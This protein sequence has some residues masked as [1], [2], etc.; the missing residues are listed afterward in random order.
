MV[1]DGPARGNHF[2]FND[3]CRPEERERQLAGSFRSGV[4]RSIDGGAT[5]RAAD[6][7]TVPVWV[8]SLVIDPHDSNIVYAADY[9]G[10]FK[11]LDGGLTWSGLET[12]RMNGCWSVTINPRNP[13]IIY[14][15]TGNGDG[16]VL[17]AGVYK[18]MDAGKSWRK[19][20]G[21]PEPQL[22]DGFYQLAIDPRNPDISR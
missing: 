18:S 21:D 16:D 10:V 13:D 7:G 9:D 22:T 3:H 14:A 4:F 12:N 15:V 11:S 19:V 6:S 2:D 8:S 1:Q 5:W 17:S 20:L